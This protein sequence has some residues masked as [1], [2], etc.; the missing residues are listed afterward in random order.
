[1]LFRSVS[2]HTPSAPLASSLQGYNVYRSDDNKVTYNKVNTAVVP[3]TTYT[4]MN[5]TYAK[6][7]Y[8]VTS[9]FTECNSDSS[10]V[11]LA[12][13]IVGIDPI[14]NVGGISIYPNP[15]SDIVNVKSDNN[16]TRIDVMNFVGQTVYANSDVTAKTSK[17][18]VSSFTAGVYFV[19]VT[20]SE[21]VRTV[22]ITVTH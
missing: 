8:Y 17:I 18:N 5:V 22:K 12:D 19:K 13:V 14:S 6:H 3:G 16:I 10:N 4:D 11:V 9:V 7:Y 15:A 21:G 20:T 1:M 2:S